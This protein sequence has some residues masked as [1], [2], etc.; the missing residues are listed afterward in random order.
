M[1]I[2]ALTNSIVE[3]VKAL[4]DEKE[5]KTE[6]G[7]IEATA[8]DGTVVMILFEGETL[9]EGLAIFLEADGEQVPVP[10]GEYALTDGRTIV[11]AEDGVVG[12]IT[13]VE[14]EMDKEGVNKDEILDAV[15][16]LVDEVLGSFMTEVKKSMTEFTER[17]LQEFKK[18]LKLPGADPLRK[19]P[20]PK[21]RS[22]FKSLN[23]KVRE[24]KEG[25]QE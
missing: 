7:S 16:E 17:Q 11:V 23:A 6:F 19:D 4:F 14:E 12:S 25:G 20:E 13:E 2:E 8:A 10:T 18:E 9:S 1:D 3:K 15:S 22:T 24:R 21:T 5:Q